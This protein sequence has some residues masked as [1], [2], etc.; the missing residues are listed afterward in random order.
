MAF[1]AWSN[2]TKK[3]MLILLI[4]F[5]K[6]VFAE[7]LMIQLRSKEWLQMIRDYVFELT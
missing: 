3:G 5:N 6:T 2:I 4:Q 7:E 1:I